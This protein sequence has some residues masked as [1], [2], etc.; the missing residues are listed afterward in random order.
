[1]RK[2]YINELGIVLRLQE[3][4]DDADY[5]YSGPEQLYGLLILWDYTFNEELKTKYNDALEFSLIA[6]VEILQEEY[7]I[8][9]RL[10]FLIKCI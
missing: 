6:I 8:S 2:R 10:P 7:A 4:I 9:F 3:L 5:S 1:L